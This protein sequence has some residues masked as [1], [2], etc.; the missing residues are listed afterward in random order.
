MVDEFADPLPLNVICRSMGV[1]IE[2][3]PQFH[4]WVADIG[5]GLFD[6]GPDIAT[7]EGQARRAKGEAANAAFKQYLTGLIEKAKKSPGPGMI[8][9][10]VHDDGPDGRMSLSALVNNA[11]LI[12]TAGHD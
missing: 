8:S 12:F 2:D 4:T 10:L 5:A 3:E 1:P 6:L 11:Q 7:E 9:Q